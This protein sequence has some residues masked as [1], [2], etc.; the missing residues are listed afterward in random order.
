MA[1]APEEVKQMAARSGVAREYF[2][3]ADFK[4][5]AAALPDL[6]LE[7]IRGEIVINPACGRDYFTIEE[8]KVVADVLPDYRLELINGELVMTRPDKRHQ[9]HNRRIT[10]LLGLHAAQIVAIGCEPDGGSA[11]Y[12][13]PEV[14]ALQLADETGGGPSDVCPDASVTYRDYPEVDRRPPAL[15]VIE[16]PSDS[17][18]ENIERDLKTKV[19]IY[20]ALEIPTYWIV[21]RRDESVTIYTRPL[22]GEYRSEVKC[23]GEDILPAPG[24][25][26]LQI[27]PAQIFAE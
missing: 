2:T 6:R 19:R 24:L 17:N 23:R 21:D 13:V 1:T 22:G 16:I 5:V 12:E 8:F 11:F 18:S 27:T 9:K 3:I 26:F 15:L 20:A 14:L 4:E 25:E 7:L 10:T